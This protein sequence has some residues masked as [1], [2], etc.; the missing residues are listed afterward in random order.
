MW[1][2]WKKRFLTISIFGGCGCPEISDFYLFQH[3]ED[4]G[5]LEQKWFLTF[6]TFDGLGG[7]GSDL[8]VLKEEIFNSFY[9]CRMWSSWKKR[10]F[11]VSTFGECSGLEWIDFEQFL[12][13]V[14]LVLKEEIFN[15]FYIW[16]MWWSWKKWFLTFSTLGGW[17]G[18]EI[19]NF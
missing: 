19:T 16:K 3:C 5:C 1:F 2:S 11:T 15:S 4:V 18:L 10:F 13:F 8:V 17:G 9:I 14:G 12:L 6:S 7:I